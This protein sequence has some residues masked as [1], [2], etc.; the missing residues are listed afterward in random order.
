MD[1]LAAPHERDGVLI[2][3]I[4]G[5]FD[6]GNAADLERHLGEVATP[7]TPVIL[8]FSDT[9]YID[10]SVLAVLIRRKKALGTRVAFVVPKSSKVRLIF[11]VAGVLEVLGVVESV[12]DALKI[13]GKT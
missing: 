13:F 3:P 7:G 2:L 9:G 1:Q 5:E 10:S 4:S 12:D 8:D 6:V 11:D